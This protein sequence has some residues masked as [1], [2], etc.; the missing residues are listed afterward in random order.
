MSRFDQAGGFQTGPLALKSAAYF[1]LLAY[2]TT[3]SL[4]VLQDEEKCD[5]D[6]RAFF[7]SGYNHRSAIEMFHPPQCTKLQLY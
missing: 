2:S 7:P 4:N 1:I 3:T 6:P 5:E